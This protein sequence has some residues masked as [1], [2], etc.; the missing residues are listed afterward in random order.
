MPGRRQ[1]CG[2]RRRAKRPDRD[3]AA[4]TT[5]REDLQP[6]KTDQEGGLTLTL[7]CFVTML[8]TL[9]FT[10]DDQSLRTIEYI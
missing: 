9:G 4:T 2:R 7:T 6:K 3:R 5:S 10:I 1:G 8:L